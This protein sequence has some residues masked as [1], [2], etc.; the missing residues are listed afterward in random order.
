MKTEGVK[1]KRKETGSEEVPTQGSSRH[2]KVKN[3]PSYFPKQSQRK[4]KYFRRNAEAPWDRGTQARNIFTDSLDVF[5]HPSSLAWR[6]IKQDHTVQVDRRGGKE[7]PTKAPLVTLLWE[8][9]ISQ[10]GRNG[11]ERGEKK[12]TKA[13]LNDASFTKELEQA[14]VKLERNLLGRVFDDDDEE[15]QKSRVTQ[16]RKGADSEGTTRLT[17]REHVLLAQPHP[18]QRHAASVDE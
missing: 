2:L 17:V 10:T 16:F 15:T 14:E 5:R 11:L 18:N 9:G 3:I 12:Q 13:Q 6:C 4:A 8:R 7:G 1:R